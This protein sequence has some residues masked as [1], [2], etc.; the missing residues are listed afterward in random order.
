[1]W[2]GDD[3]G[4]GKGHSSAQGRLSWAPSGAALDAFVAVNGEGNH[5][6]C[7]YREQ[8][9]SALDRV[10]ARQRTGAPDHS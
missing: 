5:E 9:R 4:S 2:A 6:D 7:P 10:A 8:A 1:M 3:Q